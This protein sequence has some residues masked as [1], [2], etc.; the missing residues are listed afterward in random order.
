VSVAGLELAKDAN[1]AGSSAILLS[2]RL[3]LL[4]QMPEMAQS[5]GHRIYPHKNKT[6]KK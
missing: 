2:L 4:Q 6:E 1:A 3:L 5:D